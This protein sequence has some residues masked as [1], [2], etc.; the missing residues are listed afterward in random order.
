[1]ATTA[2]N[3]GIHCPAAAKN[4]GIIGL[5]Y[6]GR[7]ILRNLYEMGRLHTACDLNPDT[8]T[9]R[10]TEFP[11]SN[12]TQR[13]EDILED[14]A[15]AAVI[16]STPAA[17][18]YEM[19]KKALF[20]GKDVF[21]EKPLAMNTVNGRELVDVAAAKDKILMVG[22]I[23]QYHPSVIK[24]KGLIDAG[25]LGNVRYVYSNRLNIGKL[26]IEE[27]ILWSFAPHDISVILMLV[28]EE[29]VKVG[30]F[31][32]EYL[33]EGIA[34][35]TLSTLEFRNGVKAHI[36]VSWLHPF[37]EQK[38]IV[39]G[40]K[41]MAVFD[42]LTE[43]KLF[44]YPHKIEWHDGKIPVAYKAEHYCVKAEKKEPLKEE[45]NHFIECIS[46][47]TAPRTGGE[48]GLRVLKVLEEAENS[49][50]YEPFPVAES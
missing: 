21:V 18:H 45:L 39:V 28:G 26:R 36:F 13:F 32:A 31:K 44:I 14:P 1:M 40:S 49:V 47:R 23:L 30:C 27:N 38:L 29:P 9:A 4:I 48:E 22:H 41:A 37:K 5:G 11:K 12:Y 17:T 42:D 20:A 43:E 3:A 24:L 50:S 16:I 10:K 7:N 34:D 6:W 33:S 19:A 25:V 2:K 46:R 35:V 8:I 15:I